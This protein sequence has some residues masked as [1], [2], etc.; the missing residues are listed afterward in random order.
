[1]QL[2]GT[3]ANTAPRFTAR[4]T[5]LTSVLSAV[6]LLVLLGGSALL[7]R[8]SLGSGG[9]IAGVKL[10]GVAAGGLDTAG[11][12]RLVAAEAKA[13]AQK[14]VVFLVGQR[15]FEAEHR[16]IGARIHRA[17]TRA[18]LLAAGKSGD[19]LQDLADRMA[20]RRGRLALSPSIRL[21]TDRALA[22]FRRLKES[23]DRQ[24]VDATLDLE[25]QQV[26]PAEDGYLLQI[27]DSLVA[28]ELALRQGIDRV[29]L[30][31]AVEHPAHGDRYKNLDIGAELGTF[32]TVYSMK[33]KDRD[34]GY[35]LKVGAS[36]LDGT[37]IAPGE[38]FSFNDTL[39]PRTKAEGYRMAPVINEGELVD[40]MAGGSCQ[41]SSTLFAASFFAGLDLINSRPHTRPSS[42]IRMG[43]DA[44]VAYPITDLVLKN[45]YPF[46]VV[47]H[48]R[49]S[50]GRVR[51]RILG[52]ERPWSKVTFERQIKEV[53]PFTEEQRT[54]PEIP[55][56]H[57]VITQLG[58]PGYRL[59]RRRLFYRGKGKEPAKSDKWDVYY[60]PTTQYVKVGT[61][62]ANPEW[63]PPKKRDPWGEVASEFSMSQ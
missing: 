58:V 3:L 26:L 35:N 21:D 63:E 34:R 28:T 39:G 31:V 11:V 17:E 30:A 18:R 15:T 5:W 29:P 22:F 33:D 14:K 52:K 59:E 62:P 37:V 54:D 43:L 6:L 53:I 24:P 60:P 16:E 41:I 42:Y 9:T 12:R 44:A 36:K 40:G 23:V 49:V 2:S 51:V 10:A 50:Q 56:G 20:A 45:P 46:P 48:F 61:G 13:F 7:Y 47:M 8:H 27:Y 57:K 55:A 25:N 1:M 19:L 32:S 4:V 38:T